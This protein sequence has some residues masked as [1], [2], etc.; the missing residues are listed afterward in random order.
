MATKF[1]TVRNNSNRG[2]QV[3]LDCLR[4]MSTKLFTLGNHVTYGN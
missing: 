1:F 2:N 4:T 3:G